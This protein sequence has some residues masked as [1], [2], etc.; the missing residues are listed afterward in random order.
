[1]D[2]VRFEDYS[3]RVM[4]LINSRINIALEEAAGEMESAVKRNTRVD[5][6]QLKNSWQH[7]VVESEHTAYI[8][9]PLENA[10]WEEFGTGE[11]AKETGH[12]GRETPWRYKDEK[13]KW[14][15]TTGKKPSRALDRAFNSKKE[16]LKKLIQ[17]RIKELE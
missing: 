5:T 16:K 11:H 3:I 14:H 15:T 10:I 7:Q 12:Q 1:M 9:S 4:E 2:N 6:G 17:K 13:G 8:G